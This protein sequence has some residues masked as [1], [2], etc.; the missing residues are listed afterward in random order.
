[1]TTEVRFQLRIRRSTR[2]ICRD[3]PAFSQAAPGGNL[4]C[5]QWMAG[6]DSGWIRFY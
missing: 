6:C 4:D 3:K 2:R 5:H 1:V